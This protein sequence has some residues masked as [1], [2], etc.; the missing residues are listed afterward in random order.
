MA[1]DFLRVYTQ[2]FIN[3][4]IYRDSPADLDGFYDSQTGK[5]AD[6]YFVAGMDIKGFEQY[7]Q[8]VPAES[9][10]PGALRVCKPGERFFVFSS[11][12]R[13]DI[14]NRLTQSVIICPPKARPRQGRV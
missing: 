5:G 1:E 6:A 3:V 11:P 7:E 14:R 12:C 2:V 9:K 8:R 4:Q 10:R 13:F